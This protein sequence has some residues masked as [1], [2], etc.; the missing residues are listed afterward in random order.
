MALSDLKNL[1]IADSY[2]KILQTENGSYVADGSGSLSRLT[3]DTENNRIG[4]GTTEPGILFEVDA[5]S[6]TSVAKFTADTTAIIE[7]QS[8]NFIVG[9]SSKLSIGRNESDHAN[10]LAITDGLITIPAVSASGTVH[11]AQFFNTTANAYFVSSSISMSLWA[12]ASDGNVYRET[13]NVG[14]GTDSAQHALDVKGTLRISGSEYSGSGEHHNRVA[15]W[16]SGSIIP[17]TPEGV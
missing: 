4:I 3:I 12:S 13:G 2:Q 10:N 6:A 16:L 15:M 11:A 14:I 5:A 17:E 1:Q 7:V 9:N 8:S